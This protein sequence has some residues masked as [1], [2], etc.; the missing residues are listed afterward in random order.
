M[1]Y[2]VEPTYQFAA[3]LSPEH[4]SGTA[5]PPL[6]SVPFKWEEQP[7]KPR[8]CTDIILRPEPAARCLE[9]PPCRITKMPSPT[10]VLDGPDN[11]GRPKFSSFRLFREKQISFDSSS[12]SGGGSPQSYV[13]VGKKSSGRLKM[14][15]LFGRSLR[16]RS[17][18]KEA[19]EG[20]LGFSPSSFAGFESHVEGKKIASIS[21]SSPT[22]LLATMY[23]GLKQAIPWKRTRK[24]KKE[25]SL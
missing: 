3:A 14:S 10:T 11:L 25:G 16:V 13:T 5:T 4:P 23:E 17:G 9:L 22:P 24:S 7:G 8:P 12:G 21:R 1:L 19:D 2:Q 15:R 6:A 20:S 18:G